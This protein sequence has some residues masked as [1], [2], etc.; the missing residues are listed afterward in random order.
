[1]TVPYRTNTALHCRGI[2]L[3]PVSVDNKVQL[4]I[5]AVNTSTVLREREKNHNCRSYFCYVPVAY[6]TLLNLSPGCWDRTQ[7][8]CK[9]CIGNKSLRSLGKIFST[10]VK[11]FSKMDLEGTESY[12]PSKF[13]H[14]TLLPTVHFKNKQ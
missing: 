12:E 11:E 5:P 8:C 2:V 3:V 13:E 1:M 4:S 10:I 9:V 7:D 6:S 14:L